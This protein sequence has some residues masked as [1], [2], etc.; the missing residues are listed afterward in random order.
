MCRTLGALVAR[1]QVINPY[2]LVAWCGATLTV[3]CGGRG[4]HHPS[5]KS[6]LVANEIKV[7]GK[8]SVSLGGLAF[9]AS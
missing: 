4:D 3:L 2:S 1:Q 8:L 9:V 7:T 6:S 5:W